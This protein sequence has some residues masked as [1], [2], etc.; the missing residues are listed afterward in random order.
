ME[1]SWTISEGTGDFIPVSAGVQPAIV[2]FVSNP[3][4]E[5]DKFSDDEE[6]VEFFHV[7]FEVDEKTPNG[8]PMSIRRKYRKSLH[9]KSNFRKDLIGV[10][11]GRDLTAEE[12]ANF[13]PPSIVG[14]KCQVLVEHK[15]S[16]DGQKTWA[17]VTKVLPA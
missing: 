3:Y 14:M 2:K 12:R 15:P 4:W 6:K 9:P 11:G 8:D 10:L 7:D 5:V 1:T 17:N 13:V 16:T